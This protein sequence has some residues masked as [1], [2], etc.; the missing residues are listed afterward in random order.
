MSTQKPH[1]QRSSLN[2]GLW[3][4]LPYRYAPVDTRT[5][6]GKTLRDA[7]LTFEARTLA[8]EL[9]QVNPLQSQDWT[10]RTILSGHWKGRRL[11]CRY[12]E[13]LNEWQYLERGTVHVLRLGASPSLTS[14]FPLRDSTSESPV[15]RRPTVVDS[16]IDGGYLID[17]VQ[18]QGCTP[19][20]S[21]PLTDWG[22]AQV[23][24][25]PAARLPALYATPVSDVLQQLREAT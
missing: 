21:E 23:S 6:Y 15:Q 1:I 11:L 9:A 16:H 2:I 17:S 13:K 20:P 4:V 24:G 22:I 12:R 10:W 5:G 18:P 8:W 19:S 25:W 14:L 3:V 7:W